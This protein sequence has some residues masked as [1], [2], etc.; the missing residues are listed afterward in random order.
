M[1][2]S[3][4]VALYWQRSEQALAETADKYGSYCRT[5]ARRILPG[6]EDAEECVNDAYLAAWN[7]I[8]P[9]QP[10]SLGGYLGKLTRRIALK[11]YRDLHAQK[12]SGDTLTVALEELAECIGGSEAPE[13]ALAGTALLEALT[14]FVQHLPVVQRRVFLRRYWYL[15]SIADIASDFGFTQSKVKSMLSRIREK[16]RHELC[17]EGFNL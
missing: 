9:H 4:I 8:P 14:G 6:A 11:K 12:R 1:E 3:R 13:E 7:S 10:E 15:D 16:L 5:V 17:K 2:D